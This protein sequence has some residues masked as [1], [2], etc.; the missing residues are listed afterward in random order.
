MRSPLYKITFILLSIFII[1]SLAGNFAMSS[2]AKK[3]YK[4]PP[5][6][7]GLASLTIPGLGQ[8]L[9]GDIETGILHFVIFLGFFGLA[10][11]LAPVTFGFSVFFVPLPWVIYSGVDA[12]RRAYRSDI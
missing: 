12:H 9:L 6:L 8:I 1:Q 3:T 4:I 11:I 2:E 7:A 5:I 10:Y